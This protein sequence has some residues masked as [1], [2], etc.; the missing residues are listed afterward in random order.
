[1]WVPSCDDTGALSP[2]PIPVPLRLA[3]ASRPPL[4]VRPVHAAVAV[5]DPLALREHPDDERDRQPE[6]QEHEDDPGPGGHGDHPKNT[7]TRS[8]ASDPVSR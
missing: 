4:G 2:V 3:V 5:A 1:M 8:L 7:S 6:Q